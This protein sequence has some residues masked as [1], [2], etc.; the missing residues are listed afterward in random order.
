MARSGIL[1]VLARSSIPC[2]RT[3]TTSSDG[4]SATT[5]TD[6]P[7]VSRPACTTTTSAPPA[8]PSPTC[9][10]I[11]EG[12]ILLTETIFFYND[13]DLESFD[14]SKNAGRCARLE[15][16]TTTVGAPTETSARLTA[17]VTDAKG[18]G[19][20]NDRSLGIGPP[21]PYTS[22]MPPSRTS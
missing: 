21:H 2:L 13:L 20:M 3:F 19:R 6:L 16:T 4:H 22:P 7:T 17:T 10:S 11:A 12:T 14:A 8:A 5:K 9:H 18:K 1:A 15:P